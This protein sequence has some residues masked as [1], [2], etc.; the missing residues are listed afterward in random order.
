MSKELEMN[1]DGS[2]ERTPSVRDFFKRI[3]RI[4]GVSAIFPLAVLVIF[5]TPNN[6]CFPHEG[7]SHE[8]FE[9]GSRLRHYGY[10]HDLRAANRRCRPVPGFR[11]GLQLRGLRDDPLMPPA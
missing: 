5:L 10:R 8:C 11:F 9:A 7:K 2:H 6:R 4:Q 3:S 1:L